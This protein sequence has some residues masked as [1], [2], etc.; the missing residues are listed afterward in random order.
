VRRPR[1]LAG[2]L[3][4]WQ[5]SVVLVVLFGA[6][7]VLDRYL[8]QD[9]VSDVTAALEREARTV[10]QALPAEDA[11]LQAAVTS[12]G[13]ASGTRITVVRTDGTVLADSE[14]DPATMENHADRPEIRQALDGQVGA[15]SRDSETLGI[16]FRY[17]ALPPRG[18]RIV[19]V[20]LPLTQVAHRRATVRT[21]VVL[22]LLAAA[23]LASLG[24]LLVSRGVTRPLRKTTESVRRLGHGDLKVRIQP[25]GPLEFAQLAETL[26]VMAARLEAQVRASEEDR[27]TRDLILSSMTEGILLAGPDGN[28]RFANTVLDRQ[29]GERPSSTTSLVPTP[30]RDAVRA[31]ADHHSS[32]TVEVEVGVPTRWL[33]GDAIPVDQEGSVLLVLRDITEMR[34]LD[35]VRRD[36]VAN[37]SHELKTPAASIR[38]TAETIRTAALDDPDVVPRFA[39]QLEREAVRLS[40]IISDLLDLSRLETGSDLV[41]EVAL[42]ELVRDEVG[43][44][45]AAAAAVGVQIAFELPAVPRVHGSARDLGLMVRNLVDNAIRYSPEGGRVRVA[46]GTEDGSVILTVADTGVGI[47][48]RDLERVFERFYRVDRARSRETGGTG[49]GL[50]IVKHVAENHGGSV[51]VESELGQGSTFE[52]R[53]PASS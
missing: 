40:R 46:I 23:G 1:T 18:D 26:N 30:L 14:H 10:Q 16:P 48:R 13:E 53:L 47:P 2:R 34:R 39:A 24:A 25:D 8:E 49:L 52:V 28:L 45:E 31:A 36:F 44:L 21:A 22:G 41:E 3:F 33:R 17:V 15:G 9:A 29:L 32:H 7:L 27:R 50:S 43:R 4:V 6:G 37:A 11:A 5:L 38:A 51:H 20:A 35:A 19:R 42:D 12:L